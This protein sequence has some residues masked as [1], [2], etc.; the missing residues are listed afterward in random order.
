MEKKLKKICD[1]VFELPP[2]ARRVWP[3][4]EHEPLII[5]LT[6]HF[7]SCSPGR[8]KEQEEFWNWK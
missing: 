8:I 6:L 4:S 3:A 2:G 7:S 1:L 5:R